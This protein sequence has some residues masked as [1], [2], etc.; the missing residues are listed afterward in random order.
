MKIKSHKELIEGHN[1]VTF[2]HEY[3][4]TNTLVYSDT[5][6]INKKTKIKALK[7]DFIE[8]LKGMNEIELEVLEHALIENKINVTI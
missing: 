3:V 7:Y 8:Y 4:D 6:I 1:T 5:F 2:Y